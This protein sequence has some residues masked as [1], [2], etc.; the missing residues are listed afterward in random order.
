MYTNVDMQ[1]SAAPSP[2][3]LDVAATLLLDKPRGPLL[4]PE[5]KPLLLSSLDR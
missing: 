4:A 1:Y 2:G 3:L 5:D